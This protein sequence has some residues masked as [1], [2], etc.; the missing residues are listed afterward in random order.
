[1]LFAHCWVLFLRCCIWWWLLPSGANKMPRVHFQIEGYAWWYHHWDQWHRVLLECHLLRQGS[2]FSLCALGEAD[3]KNISHS[4]TC[5]QRPSCSPTIFGSC[6]WRWAWV[7][8]CQCSLSLGDTSLRL[9]WI[10]DALIHLSWQIVLHH[11]HIVTH[12]LLEVGQYWLGVGRVHQCNGSCILRVSHQQM[13]L[14]ALDQNLGPDQNLDLDWMGHHW[15]HMSLLILHD[16]CQLWIPSCRVGWR[17]IAQHLWVNWDV[18]RLLLIV[19]VGSGQR[20]LYCHCQSYRMG[21]WF[22]GLGQQ[23]RPCLGQ[24]W[25]MSSPGLRIGIHYRGGCGRLLD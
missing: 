14:R 19:Q 21:I 1:M 23:T 10:F 15:H 17:W 2:T 20:Q 25:Y 6:Y 8:L 7:G 18:C 11:Q 13:H 12:G 4:S 24:H 3:T 5:H 16:Q 9:C 22:G